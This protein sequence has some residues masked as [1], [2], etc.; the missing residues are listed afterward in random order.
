MTAV[1]PVTPTLAPRGPGTPTA[2]PAGREPPGSVVAGC[3]QWG[4]PWT[5]AGV[6]RGPPGVGYGAVVGA[7]GVASGSGSTPA[8]AVGL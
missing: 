1:R 4:V 3:W 2:A 7:Q 6:G 5:P 8:A